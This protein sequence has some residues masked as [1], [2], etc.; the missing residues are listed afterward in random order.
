MGR[1]CSVCDHPERADIDAALV[2]ASIG[3]RDIAG[4]HGVSRMAAFRHAL[5]HIPALIAEAHDAEVVADADTLLE[6]VN[7]IQRKADRLYTEALT[8]IERFREEPSMK[9]ARMVLDGTKAAAT[10]LS[11][12]IKATELLGRV[13][14]ELQ[15]S[16][17]TVAVTQQVVVADRALALAA[18]T[19]A[20]APYPEA[21]AA[22]MAALAAA[23]G[24][25]TPVLTQGGGEDASWVQNGDPA[26]QDRQ[27]PGRAGSGPANGK[28]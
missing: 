28:R 19:A 17:T 23:E 6:Q 27:G 5:K 25:A 7:E 10:A 12:Q 14:G 20:L 2:G 24:R 16:Q 3:F 13:T 8:V 4:R 21:K 15:A 18:V 26:V 11:R 1:R 9:R 22:V